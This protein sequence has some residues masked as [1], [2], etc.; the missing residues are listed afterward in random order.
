[1]ADLSTTYMGLPLKSP[2]VVA[3]STI[4][5]MIDRIQVAEDIGAGAL[6]IKSLF[7]EQIQLDQQQLHDFLVEGSRLAQVPKSPLSSTMPQGVEEHL[8]WVERTREKVKMPLIASLN[9]VSPGSWVK[10]ARL[11]EQTGVNGL[12]LN[13]YSIPT[14][15]DKTG[16]QIEQE[17]YDIFDSVKAEVK[18]PVA[19]K[20][21][22]AYT[23]VMNVAT[24]LDKR[25][26][27]ALVLFNRFLQP[28]IDVE[29]ESLYNELTYSSP[30][31]LKIPLRWVAL[32]CGRVK[33]DLALTTGVQTGQDVAKALLAGAEVVQVA[34]TLYKNG[35]P[36]I[37]TLLQELESWM[38]GKSYRSLS[39]FRGKLSQQ[40]CDDPAA[41]ERAHYVKLILSQR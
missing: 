13:V 15:P 5:G 23:S 18:I 28:T 33:A 24:E 4:S 34:G 10:Y 11:L 21:S 22:Q 29:Q 1:M 38:S 36:Y 17:L 6:V 14:D 30:E 31:E 41:F 19:V 26:A 32:L 7:E 9:A 37:S 39:D 3:A 20:L 40:N 8:M 12:E 16:A 35:I 27:A 25:G 2:V